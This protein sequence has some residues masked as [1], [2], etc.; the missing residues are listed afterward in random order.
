VFG[1]LPLAAWDRR[2]AIKAG[3]IDAGLLRSWEME[4]A[5]QVGLRIHVYSD[6]KVDAMILPDSPVLCPRTSFTLLVRLSCNF[7]CMR[8]C[9]LA[10]AVLLC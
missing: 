9:V 4:A 8:Q 2:S 10:V 3:T 7:A 5:E 6:A 1:S